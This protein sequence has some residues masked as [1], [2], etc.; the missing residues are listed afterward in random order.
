MREPREGRTR[1]DTSPVRP[2]S[3]L[4]SSEPDWN[5]GPDDYVSVIRS[6][7]NFGPQHPAAHGVL[8][9]ILELNGEV[10]CL[11]ILG[12]CSTSCLS[13]AYLSS[14]VRKSFELTRNY[15][16]PTSPS[17]RALAEKGESTVAD[18]LIF[19]SSSSR[20]LPRSI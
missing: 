1:C 19:P 5:R 4:P 14:V 16:F 13:L 8:R 12:Y 17:T 15:P 10:R 3:F 7:V 11:P 2:S 9:L 6:P 20:C 18:S